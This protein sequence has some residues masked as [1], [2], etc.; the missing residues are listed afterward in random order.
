MLGIEGG[1][2]SDQPGDRQHRHADAIG[3][4]IGSEHGGGGAERGVAEGDGGEGR[5]RMIGEPPPV[6]GTG[7]PQQVAICR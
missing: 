5:D 2:R 6:N 7:R 3:L 4:P 1:A